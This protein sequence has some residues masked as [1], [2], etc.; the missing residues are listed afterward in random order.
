MKSGW[1]ST[2][3]AFYDP[4]PT[5]EYVSTRRSHVFHCLGRGCKAK[6]RRFLD[7][8]DYNSTSNMRQHTIKCWGEEAVEAASAA[9]N[10]SEARE[11]IVGGILKNG[12]ITAHFQRKAGEVT[13]SVR[14]HTRTEARMLMKT[15]RPG[16]HLPSPSTVAR[17]VKEVFKKTRSRVAKMLQEYDG[18]LHFATD[19]WTSPNHRAFVAVTVHF[20]HE[21][22]PMSLL[23]D[24]IEVAKSHTGVNLAA[25][26]TEIL[27]EFGIEEKVSQPL[28]SP[29][30]QAST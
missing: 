17:D 30:Y 4:T 6:V 7:T 23:L 9:A 15:G 2:I 12:S 1:K 20:E 25:A 13:Y 16:Y 11:K 18:A 24:F 26:F 10:V 3:Y 5:V 19:A 14:Q 29:G 8:K 22:Q 21:G 27:T 28:V